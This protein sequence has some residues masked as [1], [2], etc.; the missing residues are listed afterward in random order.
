MKSILN[1]KL[2]IYVFHCTAP[3]GMNTAS[4]QGKSPSG[5][6][7][8]ISWHVHLT[9]VC[10]ATPDEMTNLTHAKIKSD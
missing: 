6:H 4:L 1:P 7:C 10:C 3:G 8:V 2:C 9:V 5:E